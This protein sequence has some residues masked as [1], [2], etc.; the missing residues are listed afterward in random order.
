L[1]ATALDDTHIVL[2]AELP[3]KRV[4]G[5]DSSAPTLRPSTV[6][7]VAAVLGPL[8]A[9]TLDTSASSNEAAFVRLPDTKAEETARVRPAKRPAGSLQSKADDDVHIVAP[10]LVKATR[11]PAL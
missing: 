5:L 10:T 4:R 3:P 8:P 6:T 2:W 7:D 11:A 9:D 1:P